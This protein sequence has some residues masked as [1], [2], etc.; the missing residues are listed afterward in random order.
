[1]FIIMILATLGLIIST[2]SIYIERKLKRTPTYKP[3]CDLSDTISCSTP[4]RSAYN[5]IFVLPNAQWGVIYYSLII[6][7]A[8]LQLKLFI[9]LGS[10]IA[11]LAS[12]YL[13]YVSYFKLKVLCVLCTTVYVINILIFILSLSYFQ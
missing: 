11:L 5:Q 8:W 7:F 12:A 4:L 3:V 13:A 1:M 2:Y 9:F 10:I 6:I